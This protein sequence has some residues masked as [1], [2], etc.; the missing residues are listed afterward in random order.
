MVQSSHSHCHQDS[1]SVSLW[2]I[3]PCLTYRI[4]S[5]AGFIII[6]KIITSFPFPINI[7]EGRNPHVSR[8]GPLKDQFYTLAS[9]S[10]Y[11]KELH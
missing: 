8:T 3:V 7:L 4:H 1:G 9:F 2:F 11:T 6:T 5:Q 10:P